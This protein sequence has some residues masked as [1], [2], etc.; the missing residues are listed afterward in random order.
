[1]KYIDAQFPMNRVIQA[2]E[3]SKI[4]RQIK[5]MVETLSKF[6]DDTESFFVE[7]EKLRAPTPAGN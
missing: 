1:M 7:D 4:Y 6:E 2:A 5:R 3:D